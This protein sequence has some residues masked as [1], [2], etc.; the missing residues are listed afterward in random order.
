MSSRQ[1]ILNKP[2]SWSLTL[3]ALGMVFGDIGTSPIYAFRLTMLHLPIDVPTVL[4]VSSLIIWSLI[5]IITLKYL[6]LIFRA[7]N[8]G[9][10]GILALLAL[11][12]RQ[13]P[14]HSKGFYLFAILG[15]GLLFG[16]GMITPAISVV[17]ATEGLLTYSSSFLPYL[18]IITGGILLLVFVAQS[19]NL[20]ALTDSFGIILLIWFM[21]IGLLGGYAIAQNPM[22]LK[23]FNPYYAYQFLHIGGLRAYLALGGVFL[24]VTGGEAL[25]ADIGQ[26]GRQS[27]R[28]SW[29]MVV[30]PCLMLNYLG[31]GAY[32][33]DNP[34][35]LNQLFFALAPTWFKLPLIIL[36]LSAAAIASQAIITA[37]C[38]LAKQ[39]I[40]LGFYPRVPMK[41]TL[42]GLRLHLYIPQI[43]LILLVGTWFLLLTFKDSNNLAHAYGIAVNLYMLLVML[44]ITFTASYIWR[45]PL[46]KVVLIALPFVAID[47]IFLGANSHKFL[48]GGWVALVIA[49]IIAFIMYTWHVGLNFL[50]RYF[51]LRKDD[52][53]KLLKQLNYKSFNH[54]EGVTSVF[55]TDSYDNSG[56]GFLHFLKLSLTVPEKALILSYVVEDIPYVGKQNRYQITPFNEHIFRIV[57]HYG[58]MEVI[59]FPQ[60]LENLN[61]QKRLPFEFDIKTLNYILEI[62]NI[63]ATPH[64]Q[65]LWFTFQEKFF[66]FLMRNFSA[67][68]NIEF[69][70]LPYE[71]TLAIGTYCLM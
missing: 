61:Q 26:F 2:L 9:E 43:N 16:D 28:Y 71:R 19:Y 70:Q 36:S 38:I 53:S 56:G 8:E 59:D 37:T 46:Y 18:S 68:L 34:A 60:A 25:Y 51:Y 22:V 17:S 64:Q 58:F 1:A 3:A 7:D 48:T 33:L 62:P 63:L 67:N 31:Q 14:S 50:K 29:V 65:T 57:L 54:L 13:K 47:L 55:V 4:G 40:L 49:L 66:A 41:Q 21:V 24:V 11:I 39:A 52:L 42:D 23:A 27:I 45:W 6:A 10:G 12:K 35:E 44:M 30:C 20:A 5:S 69:Y 32:L 15:T